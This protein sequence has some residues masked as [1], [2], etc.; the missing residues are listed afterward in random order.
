MDT[1]FYKKRKGLVRNG[2]NIWKDKANNSICLDADNCFWAITKQG[3]KDGAFIPRD[4]LFFYEKFKDRLDSE[5]SD[6]R[7][8]AD[9]TAVYIDPTDRC[10]ANCSYCYV[11]R[12]I[13]TGGRSMTKDELDFILRKIARYFKNS[14]R[15]PVVIFHASEPLLVKDIIFDAISNYRKNFKF[16]LQTNA[17]LLE[18]GDVEFLKRERVGVGISLDSNT[19]LTNDAL[20]RAWRSGGNFAKAV[21]A[22]EWFGGYEG[23]NIIT[24]V[25]K[26][27]V[28]DQ[29]GLVKF[30]HAR[31]V[32]C[33]LLNPVRFTRA[34]K[35][36]LKPDDKI[37]AKYFIEAVDTAIRLTKGTNHK[38]I[39]GNFANVIL[40]IVAPEARRLMCDISPCGGGRC[41]FTITAKGE[42]I[43]CGEFI[44]LNGF[45]G[46]NIF[47][48]S[49]DEA[50]QSKPFKVVR[51]RIVEN[52]E[53]C[54][55]C[56][57]RNICGAP[58]PAELHSR[59]G[60][61]QKAIFCEF[62]KEVI[63]HAFKIIAL[64]EE[65]HCFREESLNNLK[66][67]YLLTS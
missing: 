64:G 37:L 27:N 42:M 29:P 39:V 23:L 17:I 61:N 14:E 35:R 65:K 1:V 67:E 7:F 66:Y 33:V 20:R 21:K 2:L 53:E 34:S 50:M 5:F 19:A 16:G 13:R 51:S 8:G 59:G 54:A 32:P 44:G 11:P 36:G 9:L 48:N 26:F 4:A 22:I 41:F 40:G 56:L 38:I 3:K 47:K 62:Y 55:A 18:K 58:C 52:I 10:N 24:T 31:R 12:K 28:Q 6:F 57:F 43:P 63:R 45:S 60:M 46:G 49:I 25:T 30:L 15:K